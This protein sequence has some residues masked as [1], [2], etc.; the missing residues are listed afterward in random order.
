MSD[1]IFGANKLFCHTD[2]VL[3]FQRGEIVPPVSMELDMTDRCNHNC[4]QCAGGR[5]DGHLDLKT[6]KNW[7][8]QMADY[9]VRGII[10][11]GGG[12][13][14][15]N[16]NTSYAITF[17]LYCS[18]DVGLITNGSLLYP[19]LEGL[20][21]HHRVNHLLSSCTWIRVSLDASDVAMHE[22]THGSGVQCGFDSIVGS[23]TDL[24]QH[25]ESVSSQCTI[26]VSY[27][28]NEDT[29]RGMLTAT[30][31]CL[32]MGVDYIQFRSYW[33]DF[34]PIDDVLPLC[35]QHETETFKVRSAAPKFANMFDR[36]RPYDRCHGAAF[37]GV[38]QADGNMPICCNY[39]G[40]PEFYIGNL[41]E[42]SLKD[43]W[44]GERKQHV[45]N[46]MNVHACVP[47]CR[48]D[49]HNRFLE[50]VIQKQDHGSFV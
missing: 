28:V 14:L 13:P 26:G 43:I 12:E 11:T 3:A 41:H 49:H 7:I 2:R 10:F 22:R 39:R 45:L 29:K 4:P 19:K 20:V 31:L 25:K 50:N 21:Q 47:L 40:R 9:G 5:G 35:Q 24:V 8:Q 32:G 27:M 6:A 46:N 18:L 42:Q 30:K 15:M 36:Q 48:N 37:T 33:Y 23:I 17:A 38:V 16:G 44:E 1:T 34:T